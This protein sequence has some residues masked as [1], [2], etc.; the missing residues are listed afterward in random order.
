LKLEDPDAP[1]EAAEGE[2]KEVVTGAVAGDDNLD[3]ENNAD[4]EAA[5]MVPAVVDGVPV[6]TLLSKAVSDLRNMVPIHDVI[7]VVDT[8]L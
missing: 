2:A 4:A 5:G 7:S 1:E 6:R 3:T 8:T